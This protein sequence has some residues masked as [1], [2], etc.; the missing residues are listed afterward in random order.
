MY[1]TT[2]CIA[3]ISV[4][5][6]K[7]QQQGIRCH[8]NFP[9]SVSS[10]NRVFSGL[11]DWFL[12]EE[13]SLMLL[14]SVTSSVLPKQTNACHGSTNHGWHKQ[15]LDFCPHFNSCMPIWHGKKGGRTAFV[16]I[17]LRSYLGQ[18]IKPNTYI[19]LM[20]AS[21][22]ENMSAVNY[23]PNSQSSLQ[24]QDLSKSFEAPWITNCLQLHCLL[25]QLHRL[26]WSIPLMYI[27]FTALYVC[28][29]HGLWLKRE[30]YCHRMSEKAELR[31]K[32]WTS[33]IM[34]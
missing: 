3:I 14:N 26:M 27:S 16:M 10:F 12:L 21:F 15:D 20:F 13:A 17:R 22:I 31:D 9:P 19:Y 7:F 33:F 1:G 25:I 34:A 11:E 23:K 5:Q 6:G 2:Y 32:S 18:K 8:S 30:L 29:G 4:G 28:H 24:Q